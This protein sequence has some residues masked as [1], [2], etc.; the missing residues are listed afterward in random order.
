MT[1]NVSRSS[2][3]PKKIIIFS[4]LLALP[5]VLLNQIKTDEHLLRA[6]EVLSSRTFTKETV[7]TPTTYSESGF[8]LCDGVAP[9]EYFRFFYFSTATQNL[10]DH[11]VTLQG[12][13]LTSTPGTLMNMSMFN[14]L[15]AITVIFSGGEGSVLHAKADSALFENYYG[16]SFA[17]LTSGVELDLNPLSEDLGYLT[18]VNDSDIPIHIDSIEIT[19]RCSNEVD[20][21]FYA[22]ENNELGYARSAHSY[23]MQEHDQFL[24]MTNPTE[25]TNNY[26]QGEYAGY[27]NKWYRWNGLALKNYRLDDEVLNWGATPFGAMVDDHIV[28]QTTAMIDPAIFYDSE[29]CFHL[30][31]W[32]EVGDATHTSLGWIQ[33]YIGSDNYDPIGGINTDRTDTYR[34][35]FFTNY[36]WDPNYYSEGNGEWAFQDPDTTFVVDD[37]STSLRDA[38]E[39]INL[40]FFNIRFVIEGNSYKLFINDFMIFS[41]DNYFFETYTNQQYTIQQIH[42]QA[43]N[44][45]HQ[46]DSEAIPP[47]ELGDPLDPYFYGYTN[48]QI[49]VY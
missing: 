42:L 16:G 38:Y 22:D 21:Y 13:A 33:S 8:L 17:T 4:L 32:I 23:L 20:Q 1:Y 35:R 11:L 26:S 46:G 40:P 36:D 43:V 25:T 19:Y 24:L 29:A 12:D 34:G 2:L 7:S 10:N 49:Y 28:I 37:P 27:P 31:P 47:I 41:N 5:I 45:G 48:P 14:G 15:K 44:Y 6:E 30:A 3:G 39:E 9:S 18:I